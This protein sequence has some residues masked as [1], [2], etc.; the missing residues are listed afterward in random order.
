MFSRVSSPRPFGI[1]A[2]IETMPKQAIRYKVLLANSQ[3]SSKVLQVFQNLLWSRWLHMCTS[4]PLL[5]VYL[6]YSLYMSVLVLNNTQVAQLPRLWFFKGL[7]SNSFMSL[8]YLSV[9]VSLLYLNLC[10]N[11]STLVVLNFRLDF[12]SLIFLL[13]CLKI[14]GFP[15]HPNRH[16]NRVIQ[17][18]LLNQC[19]PP[20]RQSLVSGDSLLLF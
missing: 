1:L 16:V 19:F 20:Q 14:L 5:R 11:H 3:L 15:F 8:D 6:L 17:L 10:L 9:S 4:D 12:I 18:H 13:I 7:L 2:E